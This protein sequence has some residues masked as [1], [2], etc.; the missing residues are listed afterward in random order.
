MT[1]SQWYLRSGLGGYDAASLG[2]WFPAFENNILPELV[3]VDVEVV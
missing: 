3:Q 1:F 2:V